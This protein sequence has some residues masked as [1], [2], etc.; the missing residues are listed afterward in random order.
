MPTGGAGSALR[1]TALVA[2]IQRSKSNSGAFLA[3]AADGREYWVKPHD[4][5]QGIRTLAAEVIVYGVGRLVDAPVREIVLMDIPSLRWRYAPQSWL[6]QGIATA[7]LNVEPVVQSD[8]WSTFSHLDNNR[9]RQ[10]LLF[11]LWDLCMGGDPQWLY[12]VSED[13]S[14]W[15][16]DHGFW[17]GGEGDWSL[18]SMRRSASMPWSSDLAAAVASKSALLA[19]A[20]AL[21]SLDR[22]DFRAVVGAVPLEWQIP[23]TELEGVADILFL[24][25]DGVVQ[26]L[27]TAA[28]ETN[29]A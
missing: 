22:S 7:S 23:S 28:A 3:L 19:A 5:P 16:H 4:N 2:P 18:D 21:L 29:Y 10:A 6:H 14:I 11:A 27:M 1:R 15:S 13:Y 20:D 8:E 25:V 26:R 24:R 9:E 12:A 17:L